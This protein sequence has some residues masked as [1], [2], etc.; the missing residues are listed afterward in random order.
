MN[1]NC[2]KLFQKLE[3]FEPSEKLRNGILARID[4]EKRRSTRT[5]LAFLGALAT[6]SFVAMI[7]SFQYLAQE[8]SQ[9]GIYQYLSLIFSDG[10]IVIAS[11]KEFSLLLAESLPLVE[12]TIFLATV[13]TF[14]ISVKLAVKNVGL[15]YKLKLI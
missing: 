12:I 5:R 13:F 15:N 8:F 9:T 4:F 10:S 2:E 1:D 7:P 3:Q 11:W 6:A 14:L